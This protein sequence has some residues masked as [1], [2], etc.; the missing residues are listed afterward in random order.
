MKGKVAKA[1]AKGMKN[2]FGYN[3][4]YRSKFYIMYCSISA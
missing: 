4:A 3:T 1:A 2:V